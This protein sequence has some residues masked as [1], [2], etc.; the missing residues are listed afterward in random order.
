MTA[1][2]NWELDTNFNIEDQLVQYKA[3]NSSSWTT[4]S[5]VSAETTTQAITGLSDNI[6]YDFRIISNCRYGGPATSTIQKTINLTC[7]SVTLSSTTTTISYSFTNL[8]AYITSYIISLFD[9]SGTTL[10]GTQALDPTG[11]LTGTFTGLIA[12]TTYNIQV[13]VIAGSYNKICPNQ[14]VATSGATIYWNV[15]VKDTFIRDDCSS[16]FSGTSVEYIVPAHTYSSMDSVDAANDLAQADVDTNGQTYANTY[17]VCLADTTVATLFVDYYFDQDVDICGYCDTPG[18]SESLQFV[19]PESKLYPND[20]SDPSVCFLACSSRLTQ[21]TPK[22]RIGFNLGI[23]RAKYPLIDEYTFYVRGR[24]S[25]STTVSGVYVL[26]GPN[27]GKLVM[28]P[29]TNPGEVI[30]STDNPTSQ[31][32]ISYGSHVTDG[33]NGTAGPGIGSPILKLVYKVSTNSVIVTS[34]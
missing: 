16:G 18:V 21:A 33:A 2:I 25:S 12:G 5:T 14:S 17:G 3:D 32:I 19:T 24:S 23:F 20:G 26:K 30:P 13:K 15:E 27:Q 8:S 6:L 1:T 29:A 28:K 22:R 31:D 34:Y 7:P 9:S 10:I 4:F 11:S